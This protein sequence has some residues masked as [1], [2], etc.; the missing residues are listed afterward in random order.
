MDQ[1]E[2]SFMEKINVLQND[3]KEIKKIQTKWYAPISIKRILYTKDYY[4]I[5]DEILGMDPFDLIDSMYLIITYN[6]NQ[7]IK[8]YSMDYVNINDKDKYINKI[9]YV[10]PRKEFTISTNDITF[11][12]DK[13]EYKRLKE[14]SNDSRL[15]IFETA[16]FY[17][18]QSMRTIIENFIEEK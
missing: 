6:T 12:V 11:T 1:S 18:A 13:N 5:L 2:L 8:H 16:M 10:F 7:E 14:S 9:S 3:L 15:E 17:M 4:K